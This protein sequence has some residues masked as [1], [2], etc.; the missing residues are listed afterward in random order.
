MDMPASTIATVCRIVLQ[1]P[2]TTRGGLSLAIAFG[3]VP[4]APGQQRNPK[5]DFDAEWGAKLDLQRKEIGD[6]P[7][8]RGTSGRG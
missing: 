3:F 5:H 8:S 7:R 1:V 4:S 6:F 2:Y